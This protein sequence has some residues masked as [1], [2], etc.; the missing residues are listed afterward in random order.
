MNLTTSERA[1]LHFYQWES[2]GRGY[3]LFDTTICVEPPYIPFQHFTTSPNKGIDDGRVPSL[4]EKAN[5]LLDNSVTRDSKIN[6][7]EVTLTESP[8]SDKRI[9]FSLAFE[10]DTK[11]RW[12]QSEELL[13]LLSFSN[14]T[15]SFEIIAQKGSLTIQFTAEESD[16]HRLKAQLQGLFPNSI[17]TEINTFD[18][19][20]DFSQPVAIAD[21]GMDKEFMLPIKNSQSYDIDPLTSI[22]ATL[23]QLDKSETG[24]FQIL[25][26]GVSS[27]WSRDTIIASSD[28][29]G[30]SFF[31]DQPDFLFQAKEKVSYPLFG[32]VLRV[33]AQG[34][35]NTRSAY[36]AEELANN[37]TSV[38]TSNFNRL[39]PLSNQGYKYDDHLRNVYY[40]ATNR[41]GFIL[42]SKELA[43]FVHYP[44]QTVVSSKLGFGMKRTKSFNSK[45]DI[46]ILIGENYHRGKQHGVRL[47]TTS[48]L[49]H[50][51][52]I[53]ATGV[54]KSTLI[55]TMMLE[56]IK[57]G[58]GCV[59]FDPHGD[60]CE[61]II[62]R[63][64]ASRME[65][66]IVV[67][68]SD[69]EFPIGF[70]LLEAKTEVEKIVLSSDLVAAF[71]RHATAWGD[72]MTA[73]LQNALNTILDSKKGG[74]LIDLKRLL[75]ESS[76]R[77][78]YLNSVED[79]SIHYYWQHEYPLV[80]KRIAPLLTRIDTFLRPKLVRYMLAQ[81]S[82][83]NIT[84]CLE[85][86]KILLLKLSQGLIGSHN[87][88]LLGSLFL[89]KF[90]Q[91]AL[92]RQYQAK[93]LRKPYMLY[94]DE[95][96]NFI[97]PS[98]EQILS[99]ARKYALG[100]TLAHQE[101]GQI[102]DK[103]LLSSI[104]S[105]P[106]VRICFR[107]G[108]IDAKRLESGFSYFQQ[109]DLQNLNLG[110]AI[111]RVGSTS[112]DFNLK[113]FPLPSLTNEAQSIRN[114]IIDRS[115]SLY[116]NPKDDINLILDS[117]F[118][119]NQNKT[120]SPK[121]AN[122]PID[123][124]SLENTVGEDT[125]KNHAK[126]S[127]LLKRYKKKVLEQATQEH[128]D[129]K[130][131]KLQN[132]IKAIAIQRGFKATL[133]MRTASGGRV[134]IGLEKD[135]LRI[136]IEISV[137]NTLEYE[138]QNIEKCL[139][140]GYSKVLMVSESTVH[141]KNI[142]S[143]SQES[144]SEKL[145]SSVIFLTPLEFS[146]VLDRIDESNRVMEEKRICGY[147]VNINY[148]EGNSVNKNL[149]HLIKKSFKKK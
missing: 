81:P 56:D 8:I 104:L 69:I 105:N 49:S 58:R 147:R 91:A 13:N 107:L 108:D 116:G 142:R 89:A 98:V 120:E 129:Q 93:E 127:L 15:L 60:I 3:Q 57:A 52:I 143:R 50:T 137:T 126:E 7:F 145:L 67:D 27:P 141:L 43:Q 139:I 92:S 55:A 66:V 122:N 5:Q 123:Q 65:D 82:G 34:K 102:Q 18:I 25:F 132:F 37:I 90:G 110:E 12:D 24:V 114:K 78:E 28:G 112:N 63:I 118:S 75:I 119:I 1:T 135:A 148:S 35:N 11:I 40:R 30:G 19:E 121:K 88:Y 9:S 80:Q 33:A 100:I 45:T 41:F 109:N 95:F 51:H 22:I 83:L 64:P 76:F 131:R 97:T 113:T 61:D 31:M 6:P 101:L 62:L 48:R 42:N 115:R 106:Y 136:A 70:N 68:P 140:D 17:I 149:S 39:I 124:T 111:M 117:L 59:L 36:I 32:V 71:R 23:E 21:F 72:N 53:G 134:D 103:S 99:G 138:V 146:S 84:E 79:S 144:I 29:K 10:D 130:H 73:V 14:N 26:K 85:N 133:E 47:S 128:K 77:K 125:P 4:F 2:L 46:G 86:D 87:S 94:L 38:S 74:T 54:G 20:F 96:Q 16:S 44:N